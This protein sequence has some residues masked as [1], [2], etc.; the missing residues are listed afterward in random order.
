MKDFFENLRGY[1]TLAIN[2][3]VFILGLW[4]YADTELM[5]S[6]C[7]N[8]GVLCDW[9]ESELRAS[10]LALVATLNGILR[11]LTKTQVFKKA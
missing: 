6:L 9:S 1:R 4:A 8:F 2:A 11:F 5:G 10:A 3:I 7:E